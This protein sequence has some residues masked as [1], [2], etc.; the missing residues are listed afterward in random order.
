MNETEYM[1]STADAVRD[2]QT[3]ACFKLW[4]TCFSNGIMEAAFDMRKGLKHAE[5]ANLRW[6][7][8]DENYVG[9]FAWLCELFDMDVN[10]ARSS[11]RARFRTLSMKNSK[12]ECHAFA[13][14]D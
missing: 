9:S 11:A 4:A 5:S 2:A 14:S 13:E 6:F 8:S 3:Q 10:R 1:D 12:G 7:Y